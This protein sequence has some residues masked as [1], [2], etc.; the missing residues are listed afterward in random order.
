MRIALLSDIHANLPALR[1]ALEVASGRG[2]DRIFVA[3][4]TVGDGPFPAETIDLLRGDERVEVVRGNVDRQVSE[5]A[6]SKK[7]KLLKRLADG[8]PRRQ[9]RVWTA[10]EL[11][12][13]QRE[14][15]EGLPQQIDTELEGTRL[16][17]VHGSPLSDTDY[18][19]PSL[20][21]QG[22]RSKLE[23]HDGLI[24]DVLVSGHS[25]IPF[26]NVVERTTV[27]NCGSVGRPADGDPRGS[28]ALLELGPN[29]PPQAEIVRFDYPIDEVR[30]A[31][32]DRNTPG[33]TAQE[34]ALGIKS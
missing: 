4:D 6:T 26:V 19:Y 32:R 28:L 31:I 12:R 22:L 5:E 23:S 13:E 7:K 2:V 17:V 11:K 16:L 15:L 24:P 21:Q 25:H 29:Q 34:Y 8:K 18:I 20:T 9:N 30:E 1:A 3:G 14:W 10:L 27:V 33:I